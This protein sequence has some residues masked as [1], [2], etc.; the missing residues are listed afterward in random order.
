MQPKYIRCNSDSHED[1]ET[2]EDNDFTSRKLMEQPL[3]R[4]G[5]NRNVNRYN[6]QFYQESKKDLE[7]IKQEG[8][9]ELAPT[10]ARQNEVDSTYFNN[11]DFPLRPPWHYGMSKDILDQNENRYFKVSKI[12]S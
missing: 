12:I 10:S 8:Y 2:T 6:L 5:R 4:A 11:Y 7:L 9:K 3:P 1:G